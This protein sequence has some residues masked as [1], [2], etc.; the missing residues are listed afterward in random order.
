MS[1]TKEQQPAYISRV[2]LKGYKSIRDLEI[3]FKA[4]LNIIIGPNGSGKTNFL[5]FVYESQN[6][7]TY[8]ALMKEEFYFEIWAN[9]EKLTTA[10]GE[11]KL[12]SNNVYFQIMEKGF[13]D[14]ELIQERLIQHDVNK[15]ETK[16]GFVKDDSEH[17]MSLYSGA[18]MKS[19]FG[20][21]NFIRFLS[22]YDIENGLSFGLIKSETKKTLIPINT[23]ND[24]PYELLKLVS[25][26]LP[27]IEIEDINKNEVKETFFINN[28]NLILNLRNFT[29]IKD[30]KLDNKSIIIQSIIQSTNPVI[31]NNWKKLSNW[32]H[33]HFPNVPMV[34]LR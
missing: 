21:V 25:T 27:N 26:S 16:I 33:S 31:M 19:F 2:H 28:N 13:S 6:S 23:V 22:K 11:Y 20:G 7:Q 29:S 34:S 24:S 14:N 18:G 3:D 4:G 17:P 32:R 15:N 12:G 9:S 8:P 1:E 10:E 5:E 30:L